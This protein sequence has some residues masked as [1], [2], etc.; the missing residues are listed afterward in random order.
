MAIRRHKPEQIVNLLPHRWR[1]EYGGRL[2]ADHGQ[3]A[4]SRL[5]GERR[6][7]STHLA[8]GGVESTPETEA[9]RAVV[10]ERW[11]VCTSAAGAG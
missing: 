4:R 3:G 2:P 8:A 6:S 10:A 9:A 5:A 1:K 7:G 11:V